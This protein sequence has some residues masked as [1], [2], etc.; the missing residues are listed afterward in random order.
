MQKLR[1]QNQTSLPSFEV[2]ISFKI[3][4]GTY[5]RG[6]VASI[7]IPL[8][9][10]L[11][12]TLKSV[13]GEP[14]EKSDTIA[15]SCIVSGNEMYAN[16]VLNRIVLNLQ[17]YLNSLQAK[18]NILDQHV[19][20]LSKIEMRDA[21][22]ASCTLGIIRD[23]AMPVTTPML[24]DTRA[25]RSLSIYKLAAESTDNAVRLLLLVI[26]VETL[27]KPACRD[28]AEQ[29]TIE[30]VVKLIGCTLDSSLIKTRIINVIGN[31]KSIGIKEGCDRLIKEFELDNFQYGEWTG[32]S[33]FSKAY[34]IRSQYTHD[35]V[36]VEN[37]P[38]SELDGLVNDILRRYMGKVSKEKEVDS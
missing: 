36:V 11:D 2:S 24:T 4:S 25:S 12:G 14:I 6:E 34:S 1:M 16:Q 38:I 22:Y 17:L 19:S 26:A 8:M 33:L 37:P 7:Q 3:E 9:A 32:Q 20:D 5:F 10:N 27:V 21:F 23:W 13:S 29:E 15:I 31:Q 28:T 18:Y 35:G 30:K